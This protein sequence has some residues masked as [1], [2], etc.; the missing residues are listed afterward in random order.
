MRMQLHRNQRIVRL[1]RIK[2]RSPD[3]SRETSYT[4]GDNSHASAFERNHRRSLAESWC[5]PTTHMAIN[6]SHRVVPQTAT[7]KQT[8]Q[9]SCSLNV[10][11]KVLESL[12]DHG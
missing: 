3:R 5:F 6:Q 1:V 9:D 12:T 4:L 8:R 11:V 2:K 7:V 10:V